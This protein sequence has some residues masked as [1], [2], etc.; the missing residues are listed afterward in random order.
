M[1]EI[2][3]LEAKLRRAEAEYAALYAQLVSAKAAKMSLAEKVVIAGKK[4]RGE[5][6][7]DSLPPKGS[8]ARGV[9]DAGKRRRGEIE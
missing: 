8:L 3:K 5:I 4:R 2:Q 1:D 7:S 9:V 6:S